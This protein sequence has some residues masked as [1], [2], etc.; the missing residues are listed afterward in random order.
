MEAIGQLTGGIAHDFNNLLGVI[1][2]N[3]EF[4]I[5]TATRRG[6]GR[7]GKGDPEQ[8]AERRRSH[9]APARLRPPAAAA[10]AADRPERLSAEPRRDPAA[11]AGR[12]DHD[13]HDSG[14]RSL[15]D[16]RGPVAGGRRPAQ[17][18]DQRAR[19]DAAWRDASRSRRPMRIW[20]RHE[21]DERGGA[22]A[23]M[24]CLS[25]TDT[26]NRHAAGGAGARGGAVLHHE[27]AWRR[28]RP[29]PQHDLRL[30]QA[31]R[32]PSAD[33]Q[34]ARPRHHGAAL[35]AAGSRSRRPT[36]PTKPRICRCHRATRSI[37]LVDDNAEH[38]RRGAAP[39]GLARLPGQ[40]GRQRAGGTGGPAGRRAAS[41]CCSLT[42]SCRTA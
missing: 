36:R 5:D 19:R 37:L 7:P 6:S 39:S 22:R 29:R 40:R 32:R 9:P 18:G 1:I 35:P 14:A 2:G 33:R 3:V 25:V 27:G 42:S 20:R 13:H 24:S 41:T 10:A 21:Q 17:P 8:R 11:A 4:L 30:R 23:T 38:A 28:Q 15:A 16:P 12:I 26:G 31:I 34:R